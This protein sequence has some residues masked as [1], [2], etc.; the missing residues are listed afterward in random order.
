LAYPAIW[1]GGLIAIFSFAVISFDPLRFVMKQSNYMLLFTAPLCLLA[2]FMLARLRP[3]LGIGLASLY[4]LGGVVL[5]GLMQQDIHVFTANSAPALAF[6]KANPQLEVYA[7]TNA[8]R[9]ALFENTLSPERREEVVLKD[10]QS[11]RRTG[12]DAAASGAAPSRQRVA[13]VDTQNLHWGRNP[14]SS[15][16]EL[17]SCWKRIGELRGTVSGGG[18]YIVHALLAASDTV[19]GNIGQRISERLR[20]LAVPKPAYLFEVP[21]NCG[22][23]GRA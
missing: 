22:L 21:M 17:P 14:V 5:A 1:A 2:G 18:S 7:T 6:A 8:Y 13:I 19:A 11:L 23:P 16:A 9:L 12:D 20:A 10:L 15:V 3:A 4:A